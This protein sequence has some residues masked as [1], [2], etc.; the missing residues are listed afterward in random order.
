METVVSVI[1][2]FPESKKEQDLF[3]EK[4]IDE[5]T[6]GGWCNPLKILVQL[7][8]MESIIKKFTSDK[9]I[10]DCVLNEAEKY[11][12]KSFVDFNANIQIREKSEYDYSEANHPR[13]N[14]VCEELKRLNDEKK[15]L[16]S[17]MK[18][19]RETWVYTDVNTGEIS[20]ISP[21]SKRSETSVVI[22]VNE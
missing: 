11:G 5:V 7:K 18:L 19:H 14:F 6:C 1:S 13:Y 12:Q 16:E 2:Q 22:T 8:N 20:E 15:E 9:R 3:V 4:L 21:I 10:K 17:I